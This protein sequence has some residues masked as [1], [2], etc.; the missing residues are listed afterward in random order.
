M[1]IFFEARA[2]CPVP[3]SCLQL[4]NF[5]EARAGQPLCVRGVS[6]AKEL[7]PAPRRRKARAPACSFMLAQRPP[8]KPAKGQPYGALA[9]RG[10]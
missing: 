4:W 5:F 2:V 9:L 3:R 6:G 7:R 10:L 8:A 1:Q